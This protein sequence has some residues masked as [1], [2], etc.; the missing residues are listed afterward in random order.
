MVL[1]PE[2]PFSSGVFAFTPHGTKFPADK[3]ATIFIP[4]DTD[5]VVQPR[6][7]RLENEHDQQWKEVAP[8]F[9]ERAGLNQ[10]EY[11]NGVAI[12]N[13]TSFSVYAVVN[14][15][16][17]ATRYVF[18]VWT[19]V[20]LGITLLCSMFHYIRDAHKCRAKVACCGD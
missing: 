6:V 10:P 2:K 3:P 8:A 15:N 1:V 14:N 18:W 17:W 12:V 11:R 20:M 9:G 16:D 19:F 4:Y 5:T 13:V 7:V